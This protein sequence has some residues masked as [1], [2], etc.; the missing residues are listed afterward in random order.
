MLARPQSLEGLRG[1]IRNRAVDM[2]GVNLRVLEEFVVIHV[3]LRNV[4]LVGHLV[5]FLLVPST[6]GHKVGVGMGLVD[7][8]ELG[9]ETEAH[10]GNVV[11]VFAHRC[12]FV[13]INYCFR[14]IR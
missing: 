10:D 9:S 4:E 11:G 8:D 13:R 1:M 3:T 2:Y 5:H 6:H 14:V 7:G 12:L